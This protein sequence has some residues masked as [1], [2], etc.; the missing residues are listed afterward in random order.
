[1]VNYDAKPADA[2][3]SIVKHKQAAGPGAALAKDSESSGVEN[4]V[5]NP[6]QKKSPS[7]QLMQS[8]VLR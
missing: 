7:K 5:F 3:Q 6:K 1:M 2:K 8:G 4:T